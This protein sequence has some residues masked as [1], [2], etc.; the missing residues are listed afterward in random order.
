[1]KPF[2]IRWLITTIAVLVA[3][4]LIPGIEVTGGIVAL[5]GAS[6][7]LGI[8]NALV[9]PVL[10]LLSFPLILLSM[11]IFLL[12]INAFLLKMVA[13]VV[14]GF[15]VESFWSALFGAVVISLSSWIM[16]AFFR[17]SQGKVQILTHHQ[18]VKEANGKVIDV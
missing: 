5:L 8:I 11:G 6:L 13:W 12:V 10:L 9:R 15:H 17:D 1:M 16:S 18:Q 4:T 3:T 7:F 2:L 14:S